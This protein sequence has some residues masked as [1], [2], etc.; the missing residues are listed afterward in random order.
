GVEIGSGAEA[1][2]LVAGPRVA[3]CAG[4]HASPVGVHAEVEADVGAVVGGEDP[5]RRVVPD[6]DRGPGVVILEVLERRRG[7]GVRR[8]GPGRGFHPS[9][10]TERAFRGKGPPHNRRLDV[11]PRRSTRD[12]RGRWMLASASQGVVSVWATAA[13]VPLS[14]TNIF[15]PASTPAESIHQLALFILVVAAAIF[16]VV[17]SLLTYA[18]VRFRR[19]PW[20]PSS[21]P[22]PASA[23]PP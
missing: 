9:T 13:G 6:V 23:R 12:S 5:L 19:R 20:D 3:V 2:V 18:V 10:V 11:L 21:D 7:E 14:P 15:A 1:E 16:L 17:F 8:I 22:P 4:V